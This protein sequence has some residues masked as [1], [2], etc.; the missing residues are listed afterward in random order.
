MSKQDR[1]IRESEFKLMLT[2][3]KGLKEENRILREELRDEYK[4][5][6]EDINSLQGNVKDIKAELQYIR[7]RI[8]S[9]TQL[10]TNIEI[11]ECQSVV[12][13]TK[14]INVHN[15]NQLI[16]DFTLPLF[17]ENTVNP[18]FHLKQLD[19]CMEVKGIS[20]ERKLILAYKSMNSEMSTQWVETV[21]N[22]I[23]DYE[24]FKKEFL[25]TWWSSSQQSLIKCSIYQDKYDRHSNMSLSA[26][27][28]KYATVATY[29]Q[30]KLSEVEIIEAIR[31]HYPTHIQRMLLTVQSKSISETLHVLKR[32]EAMEIQESYLK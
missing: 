30:P 24:L 6:R 26:H 21:I 29:L 27:F 17:D 7:N 5:L 32:I 19:N 16:N 10:A 1:F 18:V 11:K 28:L 13:N 22:N 12:T 31:F 4:N 3:M 2:M 8:L 25:N 15:E 20:Q 23:S 9:H 14:D